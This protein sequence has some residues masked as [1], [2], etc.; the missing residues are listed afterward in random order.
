MVYVRLAA[1][2]LCSV[3]PAQGVGWDRSFDGVASLVVSSFP[4][5]LL[6]L[7]MVLI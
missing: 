5:F 3:K 2:R 7:I 6:E 1:R 4:S